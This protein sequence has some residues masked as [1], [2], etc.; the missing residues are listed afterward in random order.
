MTK[1]AKPGTCVHADLVRTPGT[2]QL[3]LS[4]L[5]VE[6][7]CV[8]ADQLTGQFVRGDASRHSEGSGLG[9]FIADRLARLMG[10]TLTITAEGDRFAATV[11]LP[12]VDPTVPVGSGPGGWPVE[13]TTTRAPF[14]ESLR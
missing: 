3:R 2:I 5:T 6:P 7:L 12:I 9:L 14:S 1:Y 4:N 8:S 10:A 13:R 11:A